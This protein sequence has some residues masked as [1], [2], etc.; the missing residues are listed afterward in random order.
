MFDDGSLMFLISAN[1][2]KNILISN[3]TKTL[4]K[5]KGAKLNLKKNSSFFKSQENQRFSIKTLRLKNV[6]IKKII[7][8]FAL[9]FIF[10]K[11]VKIYPK[12]FFCD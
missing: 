11:T 12:L 7:C 6:I 3:V 5:R 4:F 10:L 1:F 9:R 2:V 8:V